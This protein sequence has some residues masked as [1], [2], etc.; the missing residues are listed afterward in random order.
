[1]TSETIKIESFK[2]EGD[3]DAKSFS[4]GVEVP[5]EAGQCKGCG[6]CTGCKACSQCGAPG[7]KN[8]GGSCKACKGR[9]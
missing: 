5:S 3:L 8:C 9:E 1:M 4:G 2:Q 7:C 6:A